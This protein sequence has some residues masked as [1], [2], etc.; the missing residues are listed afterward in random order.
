M[1]ERLP[2]Q[3]WPRGNRAILGV[4]IFSV[5]HR[6]GGAVWSRQK[7]WSATDVALLGSSYLK[8]PRIVQWFSGNI[9]FHH[10]QHLMPS[11]PNYRLEDCYRA[12]AAHAS[13]VPSL[14]LTLRQALRAP[15]YAVWDEEKARMERF[16]DLRIPARVR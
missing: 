8:L 12:C 6:F 13:A 5:Q 4:W 7:E 10:I 16:S 15:A 9:G 14:T 2:D 1:D 11:V 3:C